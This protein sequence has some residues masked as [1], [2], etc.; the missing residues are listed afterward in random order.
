M[1][2]TAS[3]FAKAYGHVRAGACLARKNSLPLQMSAG[4]GRVRGVACSS[5]GFSPMLPRFSCIAH[6]GVASNAAGVWTFFAAEPNVK[7]EVDVWI[8]AQRLKRL[9]QVL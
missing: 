6:P 9:A 5:R 3:A 8:A 7:P 1:G 2:G 4:Y